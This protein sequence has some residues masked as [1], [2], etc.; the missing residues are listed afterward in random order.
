MLTIS[1]AKAY[2]EKTSGHHAGSAIFDEVDGVEIVVVE[3][4]KSN[5]DI[6]GVMHVWIEGDRLYGEW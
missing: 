1:A 4:W 3:L 5:G 6:C 2:A